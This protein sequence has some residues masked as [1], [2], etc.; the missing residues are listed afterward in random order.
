MA[1]ITFCEHWCSIDE[2]IVIYDNNQ[3]CIFLSK[4]P[5]FHACTKHIKNHHHLVQEKTKK[6]FVKLVYCNMENIIANILRADC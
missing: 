5:V 4:N 3:S 1:F 6:G 2:T